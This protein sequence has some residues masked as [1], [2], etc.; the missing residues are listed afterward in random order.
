MRQPELKEENE[1]RRKRKEEEERRLGWKNVSNQEEKMA[2]EVWK[3]RKGRE[4]K[5]G[6]GNMKE[7]DRGR[8]EGTG[9]GRWRL[10]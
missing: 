7:E 9:K 6:S 10:I 4:K 5:D 2:V 3:E 8:V 1:E